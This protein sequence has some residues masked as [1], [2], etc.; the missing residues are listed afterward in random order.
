MKTKEEIGKYISIA[1]KELTNEKRAV[2][3]LSLLQ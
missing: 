2:K 3:F 1:C